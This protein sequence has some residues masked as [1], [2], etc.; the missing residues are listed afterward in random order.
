[1]ARIR[2]LK[3]DFFK[4]EDIKDLPFWIRIFF[5]GLWCQA[6]K[7]GRLEDRPERLKIEIMPYDKIDPEKALQELASQKRV[8]KRPYIIRY[9]D[10]GNHYIQILSWNRHQ[11]PHHTETESIIPPPPSN[12]A[13]QTSNGY[14]TVNEPIDASNKSVQLPR[15]GDGEGKGNGDLYI[16]PADP[17]SQT[18]IDKKFEEFW[19]A[20]PRE[21]RHAKKES[22]VKFGALVKRGELLDFVKGFH[23]YLD[24]L[25]HQKVKNQFD[26]RPMYAKTFLGERWKEFIDFKFEAPL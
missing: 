14:I 24:F 21:G 19:S 26:Q 6:D 25:K 23:G 3:P 5:A 2:Y 13:R 7:E 18:E 20:Y 22:R 11:K 1:V 17:L 8:S 15:N 10:N 16:G 9:E 12:L 4:D